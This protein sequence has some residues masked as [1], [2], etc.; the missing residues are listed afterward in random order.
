MYWIILFLILWKVIEQEN[1]N[2]II[3]T[4]ESDDVARRRNFFLF[5]SYARLPL[6]KWCGMQN[7]NNKKKAYSQWWMFSACMSWFFLLFA[8]LRSYLRERERETAMT[9]FSLKHLICWW[10]IQKTHISALYGRQW[11][12]N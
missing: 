4:A 7:N 3:S 6:T 11:A 1:E 5:I 2:W 9:N 10:I 12:R 8:W